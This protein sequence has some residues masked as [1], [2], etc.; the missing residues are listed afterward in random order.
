MSQMYGS[1]EAILTAGNS[2]DILANDY[3]MNGV[4]MKSIDA[5][6]D[7]KIVSGNQSI[8]IS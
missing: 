4:A 8:I 6:R 2:V 7:S 3:Y 1:A 5:E